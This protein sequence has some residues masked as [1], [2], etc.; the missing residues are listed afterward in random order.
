[1]DWLL[2]CLD[3]LDLDYVWAYLEAVSDCFKAR[4]WTGSWC[5]IEVTDGIGELR[6]VVQRLAMLLNEVVNGRDVT[7]VT[8]IW[9]EQL[10][11]L[12]RGGGEEIGVAGCSIGIWTGVRS[13]IRRS[14]RSPTQKVCFS[15]VLG[16]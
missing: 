1:M 13:W 6:I 4:I 8:W 12:G 5:S 7:K 15:C 14:C 16:M 10:S 3:L 11:K 9:M 2:L